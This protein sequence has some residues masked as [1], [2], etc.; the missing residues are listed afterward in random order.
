[1]YPLVTRWLKSI[2]SPIAMTAMTIHANGE[3]NIRLRFMT[4]LV[5]VF[6][7]REILLT[8][9]SFASKKACVSREV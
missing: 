4:C 3:R 9:L 2:S 7:T 6:G 1:L 8:R 5:N